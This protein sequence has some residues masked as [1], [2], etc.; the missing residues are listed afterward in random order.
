MCP[1]NVLSV[2]WAR[3]YWS[4]PSARWPRWER[5][6][7][8][9]ELRGHSSLTHR[10]LGA[11]LSSV[12]EFARWTS[13]PALHIRSHQHT[14]SK[15]PPSWPRLSWAQSL[16]TSS[17]NWSPDRSSPDQTKLPLERFTEEHT[18][19][20]L[21][22]RGGLLVRG[23]SR[24]CQ[25]VCVRTWLLIFLWSVGSSGASLKLLDGWL[26]PGSVRRFW[27]RRMGGLWGS[28]RR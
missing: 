19:P 15:G 27:S 22:P 16:P 1:P 25:D 17:A 18:A 7:R 13:Q 6:N 8:H 9:W 24:A 2:R 11:V 23:G 10:S 12:V 20:W 26:F 21:L 3:I 14:T 4:D 5:Q 28:I